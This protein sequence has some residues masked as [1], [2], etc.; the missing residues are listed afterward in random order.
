[1][2]LNK[3]NINWYISNVNWIEVIYLIIIGFLG[4]AYILK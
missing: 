2:K 3:E 1:M 4:I